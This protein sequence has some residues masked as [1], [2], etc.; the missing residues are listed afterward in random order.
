MVKPTSRSAQTVGS[1]EELKKEIQVLKL[2]LPKA[3]VREE[4]KREAVSV[5]LAVSVVLLTRAL[6]LRV[7]VSG[8]VKKV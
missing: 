8:F 6:Q 1:K 5:F 3:G 2:F 4:K 7:S